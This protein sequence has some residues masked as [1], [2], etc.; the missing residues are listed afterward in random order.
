MDTG[1]TFGVGVAVGL[2]VGGVV[3][4]GVDGAELAGGGVVEAGGVSG[5]IEGEAAGAC[6]YVNTS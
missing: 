4:T 1:A 2:E 5:R 6:A 3:V